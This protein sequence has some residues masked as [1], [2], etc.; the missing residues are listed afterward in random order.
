[1]DD[2]NKA[3][4]RASVLVFLVAILLIYAAV[5][6]YDDRKQMSDIHGLQRRAGELE[7]QR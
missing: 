6:C 3:S 2:T 7:Q 1:M 4:I 5:D